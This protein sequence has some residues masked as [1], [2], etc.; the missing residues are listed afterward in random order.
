ME[1]MC[2]V[3]SPC[4]ALH[5][6]PACA[7]LISSSLSLLGAALNMIAY[8]AFKDL[9]KGTAQTIIIAV[10]AVAD[11]LL[12]SIIMYLWSQHTLGLW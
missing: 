11:F 4:T 9:R 3:L 5:S 12:Y 6:L 2:S 8:C 1:V 7:A 10:L